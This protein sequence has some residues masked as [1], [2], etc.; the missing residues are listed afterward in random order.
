MMQH[1]TFSRDSG[2]EVESDHLLLNKSHPQA[3][4]YSAAAVPSGAFI[5]SMLPSMPVAVVAGGIMTG[6]SSREADSVADNRL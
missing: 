2:E 3:C 4:T 1:V 5:C 6:D